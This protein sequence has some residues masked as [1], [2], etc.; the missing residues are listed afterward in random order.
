MKST[1]YSAEILTIGNE[2]V[3]GLITETNSGVISR[4]LVTIGIPVARHVSVGDDEGQMTEA[5]KQ[6]LERVD[7]V[8][9]TGGLGPTHDDITKQVLCRFFDSKL[10]TDSKVKHQIDLFF[11]QEEERPLSL[12]MHKQRFQK[13]PRFFT[14]PREQRPAYYL[15]KRAKVSILC[16]AFHW[17]PNIY[18]K[19]ILS[20]TSSRW[21]QQK[22]NTVF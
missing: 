12:H 11:N 6:A 18:W 14:T 22:F 8:I 21:E 19:L 17:R 3:T 20:H 10:V 13:K 2:I 9:I 15:R 16:P 1:P 7:C 4:R 5:L